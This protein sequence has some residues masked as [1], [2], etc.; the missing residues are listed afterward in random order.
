MKQSAIM[1]PSFGAKLKQ[2]RKRRGLSQLD[3]ACQAAVG[4]RHLSF[5]ES[6]RSRPGKD[7]VHKIARALNLSLR[8]QNAL[9]VSAGFAAPWPETRL[10]A[11]VLTPFRRMIEEMLA[12][13]MPFPAYALDRHWNMVMAN[14]AAKALL[15][16]LSATK[17][18][19]LVEALLG[20]RDTQSG[21]L[22][23]DEVLAVI[24]DEIGRDLTRL[25]DDPV[26]TRLH[27]RLLENIPLAHREVSTHVS[28]VLTV[29][30]QIGK[31]QVNTNSTIA[32][33]FGP[34]EIC[35][36]ELRVELVYPADEESRAFFHAAA[37]RVTERS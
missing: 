32:R 35:L 34:Q 5:I 37:E 9:L 26:L 36:D 11:S 19:N 25:F 12:R 33:F 30:M 8:E 22:N 31:T 10:A 21:I 1:A 24:A 6:G 28:P 7:V 2:W 20:S 18:T 16:V 15:G 4:Q 13:Q 23:L 14:P 27:E 3:L 17:T 29:C